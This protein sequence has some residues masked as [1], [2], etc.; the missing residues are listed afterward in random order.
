VADFSLLSDQNKKNM[1]PRGL[2][3][4]WIS[5]I[6]VGGFRGFLDCLGCREGHNSCCIIA[7]SIES[8]DPILRIITK[9]TEF[10]A[11]ILGLPRLKIQARHKQKNEK[12]AQADTLPGG[13]FHWFSV[14]FGESLKIQIT[15]LWI[16]ICC[17]RSVRG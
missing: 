5:M 15:F 13:G 14:V 12:N 2:S 4:R 16:S 11:P 7:K 6:W 8:T 9:P 10:T 17:H 1:G 3:V